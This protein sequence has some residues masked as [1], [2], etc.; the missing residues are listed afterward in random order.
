MTTL[1]NSAP[2]G[3]ET[4][5]R[6]GDLLPRTDPAEALEFL[7]ALHRGASGW[8]LLTLIGRG[9]T[10]RVITGAEKWETGRETLLDPGFWRFCEDD[11]PR[12]DAYTAVC[13]FGKAPER[14]SR[15]LARDAVE[16][17]GVFADLDVKA[18]DPGAFKTVAEL[19][20]FLALL[21]PPSIRV[22]TGS[23][24]CHVYWLTH[25]RVK[26]D[27]PDVK[28][29]LLDGWYDYLTATA[30]PLGR[31][32]DHVQEP[33]RILRVPGTTRWPR[34]RVGDVGTPRRVTLEY[35][36]GPRYRTGELLDLAEPHRREAT[37]RHEL[38][39]TA[40]SEGRE[41]QVAWLE[42]LGLRAFQRLALEERFNREE[43]WERLLVPLGWKL[44]A[45]KRDGSRTGMD[46]RYWWAPGK[47]E[48]ESGSASTDSSRG[49]PGTLFFYTTDPEYDRCLIPGGD[50][51]RRITTKYHF[52]LHFH[53]AGSEDRLL[54]SIIRGNGRLA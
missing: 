19:D 31:A 1:S 46:A 10:R 29:A 3:G 37:E 47:D 30:K 44:C 45:D 17:P 18:D 35:A 52:A 48:R 20:S 41:G 23:G 50:R 12:W 34:D 2:V 39:R 33:A 27:P 49:Q 8:V 21:P 54:E 51:F 28:A 13:S 26:F 24:G 15:G 25:E 43:D 11:W 42:S 36:D 14:G 7:D 32:V 5:V 16:L 4:A 38:R 22:N 53:F 9:R 6:L 40:W